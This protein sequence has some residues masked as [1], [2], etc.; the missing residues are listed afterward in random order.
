[1]NVL[2][3]VEVESPVNDKLDTF[4]SEAGK[5]GA[6]QY[7]IFHHFLHVLQLRNA[8]GLLFSIHAVSFIRDIVKFRLDLSL[9]V[10]RI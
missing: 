9:K 4:L 8:L 7:A 6:F 3:E 5:F 2:R 1:M 10:F